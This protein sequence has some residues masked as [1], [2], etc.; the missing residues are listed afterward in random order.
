MKIAVIQTSSLPYE[1][2]KAN[3]FL[4]ILKSKGVKLAVI[5]EY[6]LNLFFK[7]LE[8]TPLKFIKQQSKHQIDLFKKLANRYNITIIAPVV[9]V[10]KDKI[11]KVFA[12]FAPKSV[13]F[14]YQQ[15][16]LPYSH[17]NEKKF[18]S[19]KKNKPLIF[20]IDRFKIGILPG[21]EAHFDEFWQYF[22]KK[23][24]DL[25]VVPSI[26]SFSSQF[27]WEKMLSTLSFLNNC[28]LLR[29]NRVGNWENWKY[30]GGSFLS[31]PNGNIIEKLGEKEEMLI[32]DIDKKVVLDA[33]KEWEFGS[34]RGE[35]QFFE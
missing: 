11:Y 22:R 18:F 1:K 27:R 24:V 3:Y 4:S 16:F 30:Y 9:V 2:A 31:D 26:G 12:K 33:K 23:N 34:L 8:K 10:E 17:W 25:I 29:A 6:V 7:D 28:Y 15:L 32:A 13:R 19:S 20:K 21:F 14:Y 35:I 5:P